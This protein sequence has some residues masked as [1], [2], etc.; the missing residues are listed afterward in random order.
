M[1]YKLY[2]KED[3]GIVCELP[4]YNYT[5]EEN[6][7]YIE[8][9]ESEYNDAHILPYGKVWKVIE[10]KLQLED[11][12]TTQN[13]KDYQLFKLNNE[14]AEYK[15]YLSNTDYIVI[16]LS[17]LKLEDDEKYNEEK[18]Q[19]TEILTKRKENREKINEIEKSIS[20]LE[21]LGIKWE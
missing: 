7:K 1:S 20:N 13:S 19:Y 17:E 5:I 10:G 8:V 21:N 15:G 16:K 6:D 3:S 18:E 9:G 2:Y 11:D 4:P 14:L 12:E